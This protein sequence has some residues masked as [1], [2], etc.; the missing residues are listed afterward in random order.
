MPYVTTVE[1]RALERGRQEGEQHGR[2]TGLLRGIET[3]LELK[4][5][6]AGLQLLP[7]IQAIHDLEKLDVILQRIRTAA[8]PDELRRLWQ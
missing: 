1:R 4:F 3:A 8:T 7:E 2:E 5:G 6:A